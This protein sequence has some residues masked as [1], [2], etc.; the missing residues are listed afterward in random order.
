MG[1]CIRLHD[2]NLLVDGLLA[3]DLLVYLNDFGNALVVFH[4]V[5]SLEVPS[6][7]TNVA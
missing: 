4:F 7:D 1:V 6:I 3:R 5:P 2:V